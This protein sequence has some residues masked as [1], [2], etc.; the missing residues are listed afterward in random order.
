MS[1]VR[2]VSV[3]VDLTVT[4]TVF[5]IPITHWDHS[6]LAFCFVSVCLIFFPINTKVTIPHAASGVGASPV[7]NDSILGSLDHSHHSGLALTN[8]AHCLN[9]RLY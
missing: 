3:A 2:Q 1:S 6:S 7:I 5:I 4:V 9:H 8:E